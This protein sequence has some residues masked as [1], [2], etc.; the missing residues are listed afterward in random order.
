MRA[1][2]RDNPARN[3]NIVDECAVKLAHHRINILCESLSEAPSCLSMWL[4]AG[5]NGTVVLWE[6]EAR[7]NL[8]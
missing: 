5:S 1:M 6:R 4:P 7:I 3:Y 8:T 2:M